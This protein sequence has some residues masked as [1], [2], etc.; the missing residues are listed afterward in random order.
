MKE[1]LLTGWTLWRSLRMILALIFIMLG[2]FRSEFILIAAG[3]YLFFQSLFNLGCAGG[4][5]G[6]AYKTKEH[7]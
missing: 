2:A 4:N 1:Q 3:S 6:V 5:C 7:E